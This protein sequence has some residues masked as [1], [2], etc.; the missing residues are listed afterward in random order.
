[1]AVGRD[2]NSDGLLATYGAVV[3]GSCSS[4]RQNKKLWGS[5]D[6]GENEA[7]THI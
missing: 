6:R 4:G 3:G 7:I 5:K 1:M 2:R